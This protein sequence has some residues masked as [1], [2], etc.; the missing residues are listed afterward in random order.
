MVGAVLVHDGRVIGEGWHHHYGGDHAEVNCLKNVSDADTHLIPESTMYVSLEPCA[1]YGITPPCALR[2]VNERVK[3]VVIAN[4]D[5]FE[6]VSGEGI[7]ILKGAGIEVE[8]GVQEKEGL[9]VNRRFFCF[10]QQKRPYIILKWAQTNEGFVAPADRSRLQI[11]GEES[12][13]LVHKWRTEEASIMVGANTARNDNPQLTARLHEGKQP[14]RIALDQ[15]LELPDTHHLFDD[16]AP[17]WIVNEQRETLDGNVHEILIPFDDMLLPN[18]LGRLYNGK[19]LSLIVEG[20]AALLNCFI[21]K[22]L[23]DEARI[24]TG[25]A[26]ITDGIKA[27]VLSDAKPAFETKSGNDTL[28]LFVNGHSNYQY[29]NGMEI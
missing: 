3:K 10:H 28:A 13:R 23:W 20:G 5:P 18:L 24:F 7:S 1:H 21:N 15:R 9:W 22:G 26:S 12:M 27:P 11:T 19:F 29:V 14:L 25:A 6:K 17:T 4:T 16:A 2:L 8:T